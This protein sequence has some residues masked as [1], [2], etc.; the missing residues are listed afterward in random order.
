LYSQRCT[1][2]PLKVGKKCFGLC[3]LYEG[4]LSSWELL[5]LDSYPS[6]P[7]TC[8]SLPWLELPVMGESLCRASSSC[9][10]IVPIMLC[11]SVIWAPWLAMVWYSLTFYP[12]SKST[13]SSYLRLWSCDTAAMESSIRLRSAALVSGGMVVV[14]GLQ[15]L[16]ADCYGK[17]SKRTKLDDIQWWLWRR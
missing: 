15:A 14:R 7:D 16:I 6:M 8:L 13:I 3:I 9:C 5:C 1:S 10:A 12:L 11:M 4:I 17:D 2:S